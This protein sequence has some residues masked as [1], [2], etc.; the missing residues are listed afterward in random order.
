M[1]L[2]VLIPV[3]SFSR[4]KSRLAPLL[5]PAER[6]ALAEAM[7]CDT[8]QI[9]SA[10]P[11]IDAV[12]IV[13][14]DPRASAIAQGLHATIFPD[15][16]HSL[17]GALTAAR[18]IAFSQGFDRV[19]ILHS[20]LPLLTS[21]E[22]TEFVG[23]RGCAIA[24]DCRGTGT[25]ALLTEIDAPIPLQFGDNSAARHIAAAARA[26]ITLTEVESYGL[27]HDLDQPQDTIGVLA[28]AGPTRAARVLRDS[29]HHARKLPEAS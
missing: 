14:D 8:L 23:A 27:S 12:G 1:P 9:A 29:I 5:T 6:A 26:G 21:R 2:M 16:D 11:Q 13:T 18:E 28:Q 10:L 7:L 4:A 3:N 25:N 19:A 20:D 24:R 17:N 22:L 15:S